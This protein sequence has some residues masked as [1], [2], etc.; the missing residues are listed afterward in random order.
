MMMQA[1]NGKENAE[2]GGSQ[3]QQQTRKNRDQ[4]QQQQQEQK[5]RQKEWP[6]KQKVPPWAVGPPANSS[7]RNSSSRQLVEAAS[8]VVNDARRESGPVGELLALLGRTTLHPFGKASEGDGNCFFNAC[9]QHKEIETQSYP[10]SPTR[11]QLIAWETAGH[12]AERSSICDMVQHYPEVQQLVEGTDVD[13]N[14]IMGPGTKMKALMAAGR[15]K[16]L[17]FAE[18]MR[19]PCGGARGGEQTRNRFRL[20]SR[21]LSP[22]QCQNRTTGNFSHA[23][24][25][26][27]AVAISQMLS[28][29]DCHNSAGNIYAL[30]HPFGPI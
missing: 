5:L 12:A 20:L 1:G 2:S 29:L 3:P 25:A 22:L 16:P 13:L 9:S 4:Q 10:F 6:K 27:T 21:M 14:A 23:F 8:R 24:S 19:K 28:A 18:A 26:T 11:A 7:S 15:S 17:A 30:G